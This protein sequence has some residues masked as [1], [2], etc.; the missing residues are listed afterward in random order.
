MKKLFITVIIAL[1]MTLFLVSSFA[2]P[3]NLYKKDDF[4]TNTYYKE[5]KAVSATSFGASGLIKVKAGEYVNVG[6][7]YKT[8]NSIPLAECYDADGKYT[9]DIAYDEAEIE[10]VSSLIAVASFKAPENTGYIR[11]NFDKRFKDDFVITSGE[12][13]NADKIYEIIGEEKPIKHLDSPLFEKSILFIGDS[14]C[15]GSTDSDKDKYPTWGWAGRF[16]YYDDMKVTKTGIDGRAMAKGFGSGQIVDQLLQN[17]GKKFD[18]ILLEGGVND[19][20]FEAPTGAI[21]DSF[22][23]DDFDVATFAGGFEYTIATAKE[24]FPDSKLGFLLYFRLNHPAGNLKNMKPIWDEALK[25]CQKW[26]IPV[27]DLYFDEQTCN[28]Y[29][30]PFRAEDASASEDNLFNLA[31]GRITVDG[32][33]PNGRGYDRLY[34]AINDFLIGISTEAEATPTPTPTDETTSQPTN[35]PDSEVTTDSSVTDETATPNETAPSSDKGSENDGI[36]PVLF[37]VLGAIALIAAGVAAIFIKKRK[38]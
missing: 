13:M 30:I 8:Y 11:I 18:Y 12:K 29:E 15:N 6:R 25:I 23:K 14:L 26:E 33:H 27:L 10:R 19:G 24:L 5:G 28:K 4:V 20:W 32:C 31:L 34:N 1:L 21:S 38:A 35:A 22:N 7:I 9:S 17:K 36:S 16:A 3:E 37:A 2:E